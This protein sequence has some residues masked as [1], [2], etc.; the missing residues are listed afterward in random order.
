MGVEAHQVFRDLLS[1]SEP[2]GNNHSIERQINYLSLPSPLHALYRLHNGMF[3]FIRA[4]LIRPFNTSCGIRGLVEWNDPALWKSQYELNLEDFMF[5]AEDV[6]GFSFCLGVDHKVYFFDP[7]VGDINIFSD[8]VLAWAEA[9]IDDPEVVGAPLAMRWVEEHTDIPFGYRIPPVVPY[10]MKET[11]GMGNMLA[12]ELPL[13]MY[14]SG[15]AH[16][17]NQVSD[18]EQIKVQS[19]PEYLSGQK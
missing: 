5:F 19:L 9:V 10:V 2:I 18:G 4:L 1:V 3:A 8:S 7:E 12:P 6:C 13:A 16:S 17:L 11:A 15:L 14:R